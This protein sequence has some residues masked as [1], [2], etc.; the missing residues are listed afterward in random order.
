[1]GLFAKAMFT[2]TG[3][4]A[5]LPHPLASASITTAATTKT[6]LFFINTPLIIY[7]V[8]ETGLDTLG[9]TIFWKIKK[10]LKES[11]IIFRITDFSLFV[12][13]K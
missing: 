13:E 9:K 1:M 2:V 6:V 10:P 7:P 8:L 3:A 4:A 12:N 11:N 5:F